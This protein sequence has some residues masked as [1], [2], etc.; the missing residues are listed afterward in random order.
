MGGFGSAILEFMANNNYKN[1]IERLG[2]PDQIIE[3]GSQDELYTECNYDTEAI[4]QASK[5]IL[6]K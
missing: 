4:I 6:N 2:I 3:H 5:K 1:N